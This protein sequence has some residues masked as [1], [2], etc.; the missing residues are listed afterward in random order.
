MAKMKR[1]GWCVAIRRWNRW[2]LASTA[3]PQHNRSKAI[4]YFG[5][6]LYECYGKEARCVLLSRSLVYDEIPEDDSCVSQK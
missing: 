2:V 4:D 1:I 6:D 5:R 3:R